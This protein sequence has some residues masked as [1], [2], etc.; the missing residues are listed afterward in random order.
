[1]LVERSQINL[2]SPSGLVLRMQIPITFSNLFAA[3]QLTVTAEGQEGGC[4]YAIRAYFAI[5]SCIIAG[6]MLCVRHVD[7]A[8]DDS[9]G[10]MNSRRAKFSGQRLGQDTGGRFACRDDRPVLGTSDRRCRTGDYES[11]R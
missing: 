1:M 6:S 2:L 4:T 10:H 7:A 3:G 9:V 11:W 5:W 8:V